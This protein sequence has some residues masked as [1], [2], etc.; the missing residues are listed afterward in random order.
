MMDVIFRF[1]FVFNFLLI[2]IISRTATLQVIPAQAP[3]IM[4]ILS[5]DGPVNK[6]N[7]NI[8]GMG[9]SRRVND[10]L[11]KM[12]LNIT[13]RGASGLYSE[14]PGK[15]FLLPVIIHEAARLFHIFF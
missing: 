14:R 7:L 15:L 8:T 5:L 9:A 13:G 1:T 11:N 10:S 6:M 3:P 12:N 4:K 2:F